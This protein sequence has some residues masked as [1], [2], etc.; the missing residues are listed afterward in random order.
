MHY[1]YICLMIVSLV[2]LFDTSAHK[3]NNPTMPV[4]WWNK[5]KTNTTNYQQQ[6]CT[7]YFIDKTLWKRKK[8]II[9]YQALMML[10][11]MQALAMLLW[12]L[13]TPM[14][15]WHFAHVFLTS[16]CCAWPGKVWTL[17]WTLLKFILR[18]HFAIIFGLFWPMCLITFSSLL[19]QSALLFL[20][21][22][23]DSPLWCDFDGLLPNWPPSLMLH[24]ELGFRRAS[25]M[26]QHFK[27]CFLIYWLDVATMSRH[28]LQ[29]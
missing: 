24:C 13:V 6:W 11:L 3:I 5:C 14:S 7:L 21:L 22:D 23:L 1:L 9:L 10:L 27:K 12:L 16:T 18:S 19:C 8:S 20:D 15:V 4:L 28:F 29:A 26:P 17:M 25:V 2:T